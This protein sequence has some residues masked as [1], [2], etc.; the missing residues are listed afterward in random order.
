[1]VVGGHVLEECGF[2]FPL[3]SWILPSREAPIEESTVSVDEAAERDTI[4][5]YCS[6][7]LSPGQTAHEQIIHTHSHANTCY[8]GWRVRIGKRE[9]SP[10]SKPL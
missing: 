8:D 2:L 10:S 6:L 7:D 9:N 1:M 5:C 4:Y 3:S